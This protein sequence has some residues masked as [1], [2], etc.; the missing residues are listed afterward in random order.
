VEGGVG[1]TWKRASGSVEKPPDLLPTTNIHVES[2]HPPP[3]NVV[4][5]SRIPHRI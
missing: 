3:R 1:I 2:L 4:A 5:G